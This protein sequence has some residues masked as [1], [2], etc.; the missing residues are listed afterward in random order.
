MIRSEVRYPTH[1]EVLLKTRK[2]EEA[3]VFVSLMQH[4]VEVSKIAIEMVFDHAI[5]IE[6]NSLHI[7]GIVCPF[8]F[9]GSDY[10][11][12]QRVAN[13]CQNFYGVKSVI[14]YIRENNYEE[15]LVGWIPERGTDN[16]KWLPNIEG[17]IW[18]E[19]PN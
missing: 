13:F 4:E 17:I 8:C 7:M 19:H 1:I 18:W 10:Q 6:D 5:T 16:C 3:E 9:S 14:V 2:R 15:T 11:G 12:W